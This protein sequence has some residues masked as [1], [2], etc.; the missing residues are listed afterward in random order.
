MHLYRV[1]FKD[2]GRV[3]TDEL[4]V[5]KVERIGFV[6]G[7]VQ[8]FINWDDAKFIKYVT[9]QLNKLSNYYITPD[10]GQGSDLFRWINRNLKVW[11]DPTE[12]SKLESLL[13]D[14]TGLEGR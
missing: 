8:P 5:I 14:L 13:R 7:R 4:R 9:D 11:K 6:V 3:N 12:G 1:R 10:F 2:H